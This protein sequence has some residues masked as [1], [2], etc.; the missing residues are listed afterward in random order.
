MKVTYACLRASRCI[1]LQET[2]MEPGDDEALVRVSA[3]GICQGDVR[4]FAR[5]GASAERFGHEPVGEVVAC[6]KRVKGLA[7][8]D[9]V[10]G[11]VYGAFATHVV[12]PAS[13]VYRVPV[14]MGDGGCLVEPLKC[15]TTVVRAAA[16]DFGDTVLVVGCG[17]MG[18][19]AICA[20]AGGW[21]RQVIAI[22]PSEPRRC[23]AST[24]GAT[25]TLDPSQ[26]DLRPTIDE[27]TDGRGAD[28]AIEFSGHPDAPGLAG[29]LLRRR[30]KLVLG[31]GHTPRENIY[32]TATTIHLVPP[33]FSP[34]QSDDFRRAIDAMARGQYPVARLIS[35][36]F[37]LSEIQGA[38]EH[39]AV[40]SLGY[41]KGIVLNDID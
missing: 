39:A 28:V 12:A 33:A 41:I 3:C 20:L 9:W 25:L 31:G 26:G 37:K 23:L 10:A 8:G 27:L 21:Q 32:A 7:E 22:D 29:K 36:R 16:P 4:Q 18:L 2:D 24:L 17:F 15:V 14:E 1:E 35:H 40:A 30:G 11:A 13:Q 5:E 38:F 6:G 34:D 19:A